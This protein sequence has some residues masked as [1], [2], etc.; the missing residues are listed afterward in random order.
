MIGHL[1]EEMPKVFESREY[2]EAKTRICE[3]YQEKNRERFQTLDERVNQEG[4]T[5]QRTVSGMVLVPIK[6]EHPLSQQEYEASTSEEKEALDEKGNQ[7][8]SQLNEV[9]REIREIEGE[10]R[11]AIVA[12]EKEILLGSVAHLFAEHGKEIPRL[13][14]G[15]RAPA[16]LQE[17][18]AGPHRR[19]APGAGAE[20]RPAR[21]E[22]C[23]SQ[24]PSFDRYRINLFVDNGELQG[25]PVVIEANPTYFN[26][27]GRIEH[28]IQMGNASTNFTMIKP[29]ALHRANGG[30]IILDCR[31]VLAQRLLLRG[32]QALHPQ[33][34]D[35]D[36]GHGR[37]VPAHRHGHPEAAAG[38]ALLQDRAHRQSLSLLSALSARSR[39][40]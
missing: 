28:V 15:N 3:A 16:T 6:D 20:D 21:H 39:F 35:Q 12:A 13:S 25:A 27:F 5:L 38:A 30:Y 9:V 36:R 19:T 37:A 22:R 34:G 29:G 24:E 31:E 40:P 4:F 1:E 33:S 18:S 17:R 2:E 11:G 14:G 10:M 8:K 23:G 32:A 7:L 26:L